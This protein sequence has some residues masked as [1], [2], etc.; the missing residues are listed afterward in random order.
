M[1][2]GYYKLARPVIAAGLSMALTV[3]SACGGAGDAV[4]PVGSVSTT[5]QAE[6][7]PA[8]TAADRVDIYELI[9]RNNTAED[10]GD[11]EGWVNTF[12]PDGSFEGRRQGNSVAGHDALRRFAT[13]RLKRPD[14]VANTHW[15]GNITITPTAEGARAESYAM[16]IERAP[17]GSLRVRSMATKT[18]ELRR[19][20]G[21][22]R[23]KSRI[24]APWP[25]TP[26]MLPGSEQ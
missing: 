1:M 14:R 15:N 6:G 13:D 16:I 18:D 5:R 22:W 23:F 4:S 8:L 12:T 26:P 20:N 21:Q 10:T 25:E 19:E 2:E 17:D 3:L 11:I 7:L 24:N 9:A